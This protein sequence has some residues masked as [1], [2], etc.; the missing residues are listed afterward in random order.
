MIW[1]GTKRCQG[2]SDEMLSISLKKTIDISVFFGLK[3][4]IRAHQTITE[5]DIQSLYG[6]II[7]VDYIFD[8]KKPL[9]EVAQYEGI[10]SLTTST[11]DLSIFSYCNPVVCLGLDKVVESRN[12]IPYK[13]IIGDLCIHNT[14]KAIDF[15]N[16][17]DNN[18]VSFS[19]YKNKILN[20]LDSMCYLN[21]N[22]EK[23][24]LLYFR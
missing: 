16:Y 17:L 20:Y 5:Y 8:N 24:I 15:L 1:V 23:E 14:Q 11:A 9:D 6:D 7:S 2:L 22:F 19:A 21:K 18:P 4:Y 13:E 3:L 10:F 12:G